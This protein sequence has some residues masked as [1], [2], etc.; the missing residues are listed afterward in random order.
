VFTGRILLNTI[1]RVIWGTKKEEETKR[2]P[3]PTPPRRLEPPRP[4]APK[5]QK[6]GD[7]DDEIPF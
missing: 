3:A 1:A 6:R 7:M 5:L 2:L 4:V